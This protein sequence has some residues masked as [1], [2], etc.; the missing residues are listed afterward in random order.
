MSDDIEDRVRWLENTL[1]R[2][3]DALATNQAC[4]S[5]AAAE[6]VVSGP[7]A[8]I[9]V[10]ERLRRLE[11]QTLRLQLEVGT[12]HARG[13][14]WNAVTTSPTTDTAH[15]SGS[16]PAPAA[17]QLRVSVPT[18]WIRALERLA[19]RLLAERDRDVLEC[20]DA[21]AGAWDASG[22]LVGVGSTPEAALRDAADSHMRDFLTASLPPGRTEAWG[23]VPSEIGEL[24]AIFDEL[25]PGEAEAA[26]RRLDEL[27]LE[28]DAPRARAERLALR[29]LLERDGETLRQHEVG[30]GCWDTAGRLIGVGATH[31]AALRDAAEHE[32]ASM[33]ETWLAAEVP[34]DDEPRQQVGPAMGRLLAMVPRPGDDVAALVRALR[35]LLDECVEQEPLTP[36]AVRAMID[37]AIRGL[38]RG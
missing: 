8:A 9:P 29:L 36:E 34:L 38:P 28:A 23:E 16:A 11:K 5:A 18:L 27:L 10:E 12:L 3:F 13:E 32:D 6:D 4:T 2:F 21:S 30:A 22:R 37:A 31:S 19:G 26:T 24:L 17:P 14:P 25:P 20:R 35:Q 33:S 15:M 7:S 1:E